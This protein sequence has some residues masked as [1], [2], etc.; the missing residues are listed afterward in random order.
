MKPKAHLLG[1]SL[2]DM[3]GWY[4]LAGQCLTHEGKPHLNGESIMSSM[5]LRIDFE[6]GEAETANTAYMLV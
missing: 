5:V 1:W 4:R 3:G 2:L 6:K